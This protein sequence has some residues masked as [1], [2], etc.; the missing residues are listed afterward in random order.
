MKQAFL[1]PFQPSIRAAG[2]PNATNNIIKISYEN[3][4][5]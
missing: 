2:L 4:F 5:D 1:I 3:C